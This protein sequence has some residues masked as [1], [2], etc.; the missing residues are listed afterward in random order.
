MEQC[1]EY[2]QC[3]NNVEF[4]IDETVFLHFGPTCVAAVLRTITLF[5]Q[6]GI[7]FIHCATTISIREPLTMRMA[8]PIKRDPIRQQFGTCIFKMT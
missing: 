4:A 8:S 5:P 6:V 3:R 2:K 7:V 1:R